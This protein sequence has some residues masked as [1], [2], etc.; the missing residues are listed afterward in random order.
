MTNTIVSQQTAVSLQTSDYFLTWQ[1]SQSPSTRKTPVSALGAYY[2]TLASAN[3]FGGK[4]TVSSGGATITGN[5]NIVGTFSA[6]GSISAGGNSTVTGTLGVSGLTT[7]TGGALLPNNV[8]ITAK[9]N[10]GVSR[11]VMFMDA[12]NN[13]DI[14]NGGANAIR[15]FNQAVDTVL[16]SVNNSGIATLE[17][18]LTVGSAATVAITNNAQMVMNASGQGSG[19]VW[20]AFQNN[21]SGIGSISFTGAAVSYNTTSDENLKIIDRPIVDAGKTIDSLEPIWYRWKSNPDT[22]PEPGFGAQT[23]YAAYPWAVTPGDGD[24]PWQMDAAKLMPVVIAELQ[25]LRARVAELEA[26]CL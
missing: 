10:G 6:S 13:V 15:F 18:S 20:T 7:L 5:T 9:D 26:E 8:A 16:F 21:S 19:F 24:R 25:S 2:A 14:V 3:T 11:N 1:G 12:S 4:I 22:A 23:T 17:S